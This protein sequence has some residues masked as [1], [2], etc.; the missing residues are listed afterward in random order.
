MNGAGPAGA[1]GTLAPRAVLEPQLGR[2]AVHVDFR[3]EPGLSVSLL[4]I[5]RKP[6]VGRTRGRG[7]AAPQPVVPGRRRHTE[8]L[9]GD[10][11]IAARADRRHNLPMQ[12]RRQAWVSVGSHFITD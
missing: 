7:R 6:T 9:S 8:R 1:I 5:A 10:M 12:L 2:L 3:P 4:N 11:R